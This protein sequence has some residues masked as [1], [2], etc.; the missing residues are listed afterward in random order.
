MKSL[1]GRNGCSLVLAASLVLACGSVASAGWTFTVLHP[2]SPTEFARAQAVYGNRQAG[3]AD[4]GY[5][6]PYLWTGTAASETPMAEPSQNSG[7]EI[8]AM[9]ANAIIG[10]GYVRTSPTDGYYGVFVWNQDGTQVTVIPP[11]AGYSEADGYGGTDT[12]QV[13]VVHDDNGG[14]PALWSGTA[15]SFVN[16][17][18][19]GYTDGGAYAADGNQQAGDVYDGNNDFAALWTGTAQSFVNLHPQTGGWT[20]SQVNAAG[21]GHQAGSVST[22]T[23]PYTDH[24]CVWSGTAASFVDLHPASS[25]DF[26]D[27]YATGISQTVVC[28]NAYSQTSADHAV[29]W[30]SLSPASLFDLSTVLPASYD[31][32]EANGVWTDG[33]TIRVV[34]SAYNN[35]TGNDEAIVWTFTPDIGACCS[36]QS[37]TVVVRTGCAAAFIGDGTTCGPDTCCEAPIN[38]PLAAG[39]CDGDMLVDAC[40][41]L[42]PATDCNNNGQEDSCET[43]V[44]SADDFQTPG[45]YSINGSATVESGSVAVLTPALGGQGGSVVRPPLTSGVTKRFRAIFDFRISDASVPPADGFSFALFDASLFTTAVLF[46]E[47]GPPGQ[48]TIAVKFN[49]YE[50]APGEGSNSMYIR[51]NDADVAGQTTLPFTLA[52]GQWHRAVVDLTPDGHITVKLGTNPGDATTVFNSVQLPGYIPVRAAIGFGGRTGGSYE[53]HTIANVRLAVNGPND[54]NGN[55]IP[56]ECECRADFDL[57]GT[58][59]V[60]DIFAFLNAWFAGDPRADFDGESGLQVA[61]IFAFLNAWFAG[62]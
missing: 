48:G 38:S 50:N 18:P 40:T 43:L 2:G 59:E 8:Y 42:T 9:S 24:A 16:L 31:G 19:A 26:T 45:V 30:T 27:S 41:P 3:T 34:G 10:Y 36:G 53:A 33:S 5:S 11:P 13:G 62:C 39:D 49:T 60:A 61:D 44:F 4:D 29:V 32:C 22:S 6:H 52:D 25:P 46:G 57:S 12:Q 58:L 20:D 17:L 55:G 51:Y 56:D 47:D 21:G 37:C 23:P 28:G 35:D 15:A 7:P 1:L 14:Y 54:L